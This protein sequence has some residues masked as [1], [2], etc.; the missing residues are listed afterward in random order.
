MVLL[1][2]FIAGFSLMFFVASG[3]RD[4]IYEAKTFYAVSVY[5][6]KDKRLVEQMSDKVKMIGGSS[7]IYI[8]DGFMYVLAMCYESAQDANVVLNKL[9]KS[10]ATASIEKINICKINKKIVKLIKSD[11][12]LK[13]TYQ[14][15]YNLQKTFYQC[16]ENYD[17]SGNASKIYK[18]LI[19]LKL[20]LADTV[21]LL[22]GNKKLEKEQIFCDVYQNFELFLNDMLTKINSCLSSIYMVSKV[23]HALK[24]LHDS[25]ILST[26]EFVNTL[27]VLV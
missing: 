23:S 4:E 19:S 16:S 12:Y 15:I 14:R 18:E 1:L 10:Y 20:E 27:N 11:Y 2:L 5:K 3:S 7:C 17:K 22:S 6:S 13:S 24:L 21:K 25:T 8:K 26:M 9:N